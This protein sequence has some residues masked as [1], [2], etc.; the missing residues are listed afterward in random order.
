[1]RNGI[2]GVAQIHK[3]WVLYYRMSPNKI[4]IYQVPT[5]PTNESAEHPQSRHK[6]TVRDSPRFNNSIITRRLPKY[7]SRSILVLSL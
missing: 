6:I 5:S 1:M 7:K 4:E 3:A 2:L